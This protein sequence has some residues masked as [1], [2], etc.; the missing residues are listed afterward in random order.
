MVVEAVMNPVTIAKAEQTA[1]NSMQP[2]TQEVFDT[3]RLA[4]PIAL[5]QLGQVAMMTSD[6]AMIGRLGD[7][8]VA[9]AS[10][11]H[12][13]LFTVF[14]FGM[15]VVSAVAPLA[16]QGFGGRN[17][18][19]IRRATRV[20]IWAAVLLGI[21]LSFCQ[22]WGEEILIALG[23]TRPAAALAE[24]YL[25]G[26]TWCLVPAWVFIAL[27]G[28][29]GAVN[30]PQ[31]ALWITL[32]AVPAN[33]VLAYGL[34]YGVA[35]LPKLNLF[36]AGLATT[37]VNLLMCGA[38]I[39]IAQ[40]QRPFR[41]FQV[42]GQFWRFDPQI[43][44]KLLVIG[45]PISGAFVLEVGLF[46]SAA[47]MIGQFGT[48]ALAA[49]QIAV[50]TAAIMF[51]VPFGI[52][53]AATVRVGHAVGRRDPAGTRRAGFAAIAMAAVFMGAMTLL[54]LLGRY[55]LPHAFLGAGSEDTRETVDLCALFLVCGAAFFVFDGIQ[56]TATGALRGL[57]D[58]RVP[59]LLAFIGFWIV[60]FG[61]AYLFAFAAEWG[62]VGIWIGLSLGLTL[63]A[64]LVM[65]RF[66]FLTR[67]RYLP[68]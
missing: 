45:L 46:A 20:G 53:M 34:I 9:A 21:P 63:F 48:Q 7:E 13:V 50:Q 15:G 25:A 10:L 37:I 35:G 44:A 28:F 18:R 38:A 22:F 23:Q 26:L 27:R 3:L 30:R 31:P 57:N 24:R 47:L 14:V 11:A 17:P 12:A 62:P 55:E 39:V 5:T 64:L 29:M 60:G 33:A 54:V 59:L 32:A 6:L 68:S 2:W 42:F 65:G 49:H 43:M 66:H 51:M 52:S 36:G 58:T 67:R 41:K 16:A 1:T 8:A 4:W 61:G 56:T 40:T 19:R